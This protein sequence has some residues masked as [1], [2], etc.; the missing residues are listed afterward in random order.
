MPQ[1]GRI[2]KKLAIAVL[3]SRRFLWLAEGRQ[4]VGQRRPFRQALP[5]AAHSK[6][7]SRQPQMS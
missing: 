1:I 6:W 5:P 2:N 4:R 7:K 3:S